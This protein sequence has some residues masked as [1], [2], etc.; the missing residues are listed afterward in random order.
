MIQKFFNQVYKIIKFF[1]SLETDNINLSN[2]KESTKNITHALLRLFK[3]SLKISDN[4]RLLLFSGIRTKI[5][6]DI[7]SAKNIFITQQLIWKLIRFVLY[8]EINNDLTSNKIRIY[9]L[10]IIMIVAQTTNI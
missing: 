4:I 6:G 8:V 2:H 3:S 7:F 10:R 5:D 1:K 9:Y